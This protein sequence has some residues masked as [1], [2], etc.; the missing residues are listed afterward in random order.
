[1]IGATNSTTN[2]GSNSGVGTTGT[3]SA[4]PG[5]DMGKDQ[6]LKLLVA[7]LQNQD[8]MNPMQGDQMASELAQFSSLE[9]L[10]QIN[11][12]LSG[13]QSSTGALLGAIQ[14]TAAINTI[15]HTV[16]ALGNQVQIGGTNGQSTVTANVAGAGTGT[17]HIY[18]SAGVEVGSRSLGSVASG[19][20]DFQLG[21]AAKGLAPGNYTYS[22]D[23]KDSAG[24]AVNVQTFM[25]GKVDG[26]SSGTNGIVLTA[27]G[28]TIAYGDVV[29]IN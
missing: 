22:I 26:V 17:L 3:Q 11:T 16:T 18:N 12:T 19:K 23:V 15:G 5:G 21:D 28:M 10:Q 25:T 27:G 8:P 1:M 20:Q 24:N 4:A 9:Q 14:A 29:Q 6:F 2:T 13:Q 7:Q